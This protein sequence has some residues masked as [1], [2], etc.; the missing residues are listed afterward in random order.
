MAKVAPKRGKNMVAVVAGF[1]LI[2]VILLSL[3]GQIR[4]FYAM[5]RDG[6]LPI[7][8]RLRRVMQPGEGFIHQTA[9]FEEAAAA[10][11]LNKLYELMG[12]DKWFPMRTALCMALMESGW[13][14]EAT[15]PAPTTELRSPGQRRSWPLAPPCIAARATTG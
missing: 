14:V 3:L 12:T 9:C 8:K 10:K 1:G 6:L 7:L 13:Q 2:P 15:V 4:I 11:C 5:G